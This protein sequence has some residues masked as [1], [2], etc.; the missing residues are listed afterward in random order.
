MPSE[1]V[2]GVGVRSWHHTH[3]HTKLT[4]VYNTSSNWNECLLLCVSIHEKGLYRVCVH[5]VLACIL[6]ESVYLTFIVALC[7]NSHVFSLLHIFL[8]APL[9]FFSI[10]PSLPP[11]LPPLPWQEC[12]RSWCVRTAVEKLE[13]V[14][15]PRARA[16]LS[17]TSRLGHLAP[18]LVFDLETRFSRSAKFYQITCKKAAKYLLCSVFGDQVCQILPD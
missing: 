1:R 10:S 7:W 3:I 6:C 18:W 14:S 17:A 13:S 8:F 4:A 16:C 15:L 5:N 9:I 2:S 11:S 12:E